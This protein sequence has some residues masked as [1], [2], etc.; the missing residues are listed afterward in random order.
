MPGSATSYLRTKV[1]GHTLAFAAYAEPAGIWL[2]LCAAVPPPTATAPGAEVAG[3]AYVRQAATWAMVSSRTDL[4]ANA[5]T[6]EWPAA[7]ASWGTIGY[8]EVW[9][10]ATAGNRLY[11]GPLVDPTDGVT[12]ITQVVNVGDIMRISTGNFTVQAI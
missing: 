10:A 8:A 12:P 11:W 4:A 1:L 3:G 5:A 9:D 2:G 6:L 7:T